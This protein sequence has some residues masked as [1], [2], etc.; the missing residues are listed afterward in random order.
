MPNPKVPILAPTRRYTRQPHARPTID[1][2]HPLT[3]G[4]ILCLFNSAEDCRGQPFDY[5]TGSMIGSRSGAGMVAD[6]RG[7]ETMF[8]G[9]NDYVSI[10]IDLSPHRRITLSWWMYWDAFANN[11]HIVIE[12]TAD[13]SA[14]DAFAINPNSSS[15][16]AF[17]ANVHSVSGSGYGGKKITRPSAAAWHHYSI[18]IDTT[19]A[20]SSA[21]AFVRLDGYSTATTATNNASVAFTLP[22]STLY[23]M[24]R[25]GA[26][27][28]AGGRLA[29]F[30]L[31]NRLLSAGESAQLFANP[32]QMFVPQKKWFLPTAKDGV[33]VPGLILR[34]SQISSQPMGRPVLDRN[35]PLAQG[36]VASMLNA[37]H[38]AVTPLYD[39]VSG[40]IGSISPAAVVNDPRRG[41]AQNPAGVAG[42]YQSV[43]IDLSPYRYITLA[44]WELVNSYSGTHRSFGYGDYNTDNS[45]I[46]NPTSGDGKYDLGCFD[47]ESHGSLRGALRMLNRPTAGVWHHLVIQWD[48]DDTSQILNGAWTNKVAQSLSNNTFYGNS[49]GP[50]R[51]TANRDFKLNGPTIIGSSVGNARF[52]NFH[53]YNRLLSQG[54]REALY[55]N[56]WLMFYGARPLPVV[57]L[58]A[59]TGDPYQITGTVTANTVPLSG[60]IVRLYNETTGDLLR[61]TSTNGSGVYTFGSKGNEL[62]AFVIYT[63]IAYDALTG[64]QYNGGILR[65]IS[66]GRA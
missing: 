28:F 18:G 42:R 64:Y 58:T 2:G 60:A 29:N 44:F 19:Q 24:S 38:D 4:L 45:L 56:P 37:A 5:A 16:T 65:G 48:L 1:R 32:W 25:G 21:I 53:I 63:V 9:T 23:L 11:D 55:N 46:G 17:G 15:D 14:A 36:L 27:L 41:L 49:V 22:N 8:D 54:E 39:Y 34:N 66:A 13:S 20:G 61:E 52:A 10:P 26:S 6:G 30:C 31:H 43:N 33:F 3:R 57:Y 12:Y 47:S 51:L 35:H 40:K 50:F 62:S 7:V 59:D